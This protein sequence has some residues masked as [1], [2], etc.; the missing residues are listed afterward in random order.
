MSTVEILLAAIL[1]AVMS[2]VVTQIMSILTKHMW[3]TRSR[4]EK[5]KKF[6]TN[7]ENIQEEFKLVNS[8]KGHFSFFGNA[9]LYGSIS[10]FALYFILNFFLK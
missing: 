9:L 8:W 2:L 7:T 5:L 3:E 4:L 10:S 1:I 6:S